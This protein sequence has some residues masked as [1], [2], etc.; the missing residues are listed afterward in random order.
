MNA[1]HSLLA[2]LIDYAGLY[3][4]AALDMRSA[5]RNYVHHSQGEHAAALGRF[6]VNMNRLS[7][8]REAAGGSLGAMRLSVLA[9]SMEDCAL[10]SQGVHDGLRIEGVEFKTDRPPD[11]R[12]L[13][14]CV[15]AGVTAF[16][17]VP[18]G[19]AMQDA[20]EAIAEA[21]ACAKLR[22]GG[23]V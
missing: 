4:P 14:A 15:P 1:I 16:F 23:L 17:E 10:L 19:G 5:V 12:R 3:P 2:G 22:M 13:S 7:E 20:L 18:A 8:L 21:G 6:V 9:A 11:I